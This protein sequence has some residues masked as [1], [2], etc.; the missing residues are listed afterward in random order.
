M[1]E[2]VVIS[3]RNQ[4]NPKYEGDFSTCANLLYVAVRSLRNQGFG[5]GPW[6]EPSH[7]VFERLGI[8]AESA[9]NVTESLLEKADDLTELIQMLNK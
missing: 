8:S 5:D 6:E 9:T 2:E 7:E 1:P 4:H 3:L